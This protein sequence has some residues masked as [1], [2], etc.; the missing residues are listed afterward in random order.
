MTN[1]SL[2]LN[3]QFIFTLLRG[4]FFQFDEELVS[5]K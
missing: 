5:I 4:V 2:K 3:D 1:L